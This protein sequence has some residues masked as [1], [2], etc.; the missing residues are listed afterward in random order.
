MPNAPNLQDILRKNP[1]IEPDDL[2]A[3]RKFFSELRRAGIHRRG[4]QLPAPHER[5]RPKI[6][7]DQESHTINLSGLR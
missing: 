1:S 7:D 5:H 3:S 2:D 4:Y 6:I